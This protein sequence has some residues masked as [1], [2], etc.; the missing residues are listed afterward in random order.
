MADG[1]GLD[2]Q[3][4]HARLLRD[5][6]LQLTFGAP[7]KPPHFDEPEWLKALGRWLGGLIKL[8]EP[9]ALEL[10]W[11]CAGLAVATILFLILRDVLG[12]R[13][14]RRRKAA[15]RHAP[16]DWRPET[17]KARALL[18]DADRL[19]AQGRFDEATRLLLTR[20]I[21]D[22]D[23]KRP[24]LVGPALTARD[25]AALEDLPP[26]AR[27]AFRPIAEAVERSLFGGRALDSDTFA[28]CRSDYE[29]FALP[30]VWA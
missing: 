27:A 8:I 11:I 18:E 28:R 22:I 15:V 9:F 12:V 24:R 16:V 19:A 17:W 29:A 5:K 20:S 25:I 6:S 10:F 3:T 2:A 14:I 13:F 7:P 4:I 30:P 1:A 26:A 21:E 23:L